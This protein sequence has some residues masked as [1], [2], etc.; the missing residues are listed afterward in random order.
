MPLDHL[1]RDVVL[2][3]AA[4]RAEEVAQTPRS[5][6]DVLRTSA[7]WAARASGV[8]C[9]SMPAANFR[10]GRRSEARR[11]EGSAHPGSGATVR[12]AP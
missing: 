12:E 6:N 1:D 9:A 10:S 7:S 3:D 11:S 2:E 4:V 8:A 5:A